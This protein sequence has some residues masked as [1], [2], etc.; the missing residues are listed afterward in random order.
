MAGHIE[1]LEKHY[2]PHDMNCDGGY[3]PTKFRRGSA[4]YVR[5][6]DG[7]CDKHCPACTL[8]LV[9]VAIEAGDKFE[10][11]DLYQSDYEL[12]K[13]AEDKLKKE[14]LANA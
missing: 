11:V 4:Y 13:Q 8:T 10:Y 1:R 7:N 5:F 12:L 2:A 9:L 3:C 14:E 6:I